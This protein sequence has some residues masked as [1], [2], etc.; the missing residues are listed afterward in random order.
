MQSGK[1]HQVTQFQI[2]NWNP[3]GKC[4]SPQTI[5]TV[6]EEMYKVQRR[7]DNKP[8]VVHCRWAAFH[9]SMFI[10]YPASHPYTLLLQWHCQQVRDVLCHSYHHWPLQ[11]WK[12]GGCVPGGK[13]SA[14][15][16]TGTCSNSGEYTMHQPPLSLYH[17]L[18]II[19]PSIYSYHYHHHHTHRSSTSLCLK[20]SS[21]SSSHLRHT[22]T[23]SDNYLQCVV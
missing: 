21:P 1:T 11:D 23:L 16:K 2:Q 17:S 3:H 8:V 5:I 12:C 9:W 15:S 22:Q 14:Y 7:T 4:S 19:W 13:G 6:V 10:S 20:L 18:T